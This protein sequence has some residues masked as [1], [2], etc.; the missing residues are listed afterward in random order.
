MSSSYPVFLLVW[1]SSVK[2]HLF[3]VDDLLRITGLEIYTH[4]FDGFKSS[5]EAPMPMTL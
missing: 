5:L 4:F 1:I 2:V 3:R